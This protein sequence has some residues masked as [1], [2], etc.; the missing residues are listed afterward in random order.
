MYQEMR[1][2]RL[3]NRTDVRW[4]HSETVNDATSAPLI[5][6]A[7]GRDAVVAAMPGGSCR[8]EYSV[9]SYAAVSEGTAQ[10][11]QWPAGQVEQNTTDVVVGGVTALRFVST[12]AGTWE[13]AL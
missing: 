12:G 1:S 6:P 13:V 7:I 8:V 11:H 9:S 4:F 10:W 5:I 3:P 2:E